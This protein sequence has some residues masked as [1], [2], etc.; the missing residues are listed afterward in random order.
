MNM[1]V[2][3]SRGLSG[4]LVEEHLQSNRRKRGWIEIIWLILSQCVTG[5]VKTRIMYRCNLNSK[6][7]HQYLS[8]LLDCDFLE[9]RKEESHVTMSYYT[10]ESGMQF[11]RKYQQLQEVLEAAI[12]HAKLEDPSEAFTS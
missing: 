5:S 1:Q 10:T 8:F 4:T 6:Q 3:S 11:M 12:S 9:G 7:M 2:P